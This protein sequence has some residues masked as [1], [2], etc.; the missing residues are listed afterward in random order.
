MVARAPF[1]VFSLLLLQFANGN[2]NAERIQP[3]P[4]YAEDRAYMVFNEI[5]SAGRLWGSSLY[6]NG[7]GFFPATVPA[8]TMF[9]HG[10]R[11]NVTPAGLEW[12]AFDI[13]H[14]ENFGRSFRYKPG[15]GHHPPVSLS[16]KNKPEQDDDLPPEEGFRDELRRRNERATREKLHIRDDDEKGEVN[17]RGYLHL[18]QTTRELN[19]LLLDGLSAG[20]TGMGTLDSQDLVLREDKGDNERFNEWNRARDLCKIATE[21]GLDGFVRM[22]LGVEV[23]KC[24]FSNDLD[25]INMMRTEMRE[26]M[27]AKQG[28]TAFQWVR[29]VGERYDDIGA[30]RLRIDFSSMVSGLF[31]PINISNTD[32][33]RPDLKRLDAATLEDLVDI[34]VYLK[35][36]LRQPR[37]FTVNWQGVVDL[38]VN[39][40]SK[41]IALMAY[42]Q[43]P[44]HHFI[45]EVEA[46]TTTWYDAPPLADDI[47]STQKG[48]KNRTADAIEECR[49]HYLRPALLVK[50]KWSVEDRMI[51]IS[52]DT[53]LETI[54]NTLYSVRSH[55]LR[56]SK[57]DGE[58]DAELEKAVQHG[59]VVMRELMGELG[60]STWKKPQACAPDEV[61]VVAMW[62]FGTKEDHWYPGCR[63]IDT[64]QH[65]KDSYW[66]TFR[67]VN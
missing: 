50:G 43:L 17:V 26:D 62:P 41:R 3:D 23:I 64:V 20:K 42:E 63:S 12:L 55:L 14:A 66:D 35:G 39:R 27:M 44:S 59:R 9:Y 28:L 34:K 22:E 58:D 65:P 31:F 18:Y 57:R 60:W 45:N 25:L 16:D 46:A 33:E 13:E 37:R 47:Y 15:R 36:V 2:S 67:P 40:Y 4:K 1:G 53:V 51:Y 8:G 32:P 10:S 7:F 48:S 6:H 38:V 11:Q 61:S 5:H 19:L 30:D 21:W 56:V 29:A 52:L 24:D 49:I 54:C